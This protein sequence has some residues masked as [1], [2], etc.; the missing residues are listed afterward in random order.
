[1]AVRRVLPDDHVAAVHETA[2]GFGVHHGG[3]MRRADD[4]HGRG[5]HALAVGA[6]EDVLG[7]G[8]KPI[9][10]HDVHLRRGRPHMFFFHP[11]S[12]EYTW[13]HPAP[14]P[15]RFPSW[16]TVVPNTQHHSSEVS[17]SVSR[18]TRQVNDS[19]GVT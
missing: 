13:T 16:P 2:G 5:V 8:A 1:M 11:E 19:L 9:Q 7:A 14:L 12:G 15:R 3:A 10:A 4:G 18:R 6:A 17:E